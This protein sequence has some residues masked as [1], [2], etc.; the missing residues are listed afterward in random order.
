MTNTL[1][2]AET[3]A[4]LIDPV[5]AE[6]GWGRVDGS[7]VGREVHITNGRLIGGG[8]R[9]R[10]DIADYVLIYRG[11]RLAVIEAKRVGLPDTE[12]VGQAKRY[13]SML[14]AR[15]AFSTNGRGIYRIDMQTGEECYVGRY[16]APEELWSACFVDRNRWRDRFARVPF[17]DR[18][19]TWEARYYQH[20][21]IEQA[22]AAI[23]NGQDR[24]LLTLATGTG[25]TF[26]AFQLA[27]KLFHSRWNLKAWG[28]Q[29][30]TRRPRILFLADRNILADQAYN[31]F[32]A[33]PEDALIRISPEAI[34]KKGRVPKNGAVFFT[35]F[36]TFMSGRDAEG[37][38]CPSFWGYPPDFFDFIVIDECHRGGANDESTWREI[39]EYF[40][41][42][43]QLGL[44][45]TP[46]RTS[47]ADT[48]AYFGE[49]VY[50]YSLRQGINDG[51]L[52]PFKV[53]Q[54]A[55]TI[56]DYMYTSDDTL[57]E[58]EVEAGKR[59]TEED[60]NRIIEIKAR[61][62]YRVRVFM[63]T[64]DQTQKTLV[65]CAT[66]EHALAVRDLI[67]QYKN[68]TDPNYCM[69]VTAN[70]GAEGERWLRVF[71]DNEKSIPTILTTSQKLSTGVDARNIRNIVLMRPINSMVEFKQ[72]IGRGTRLFDGK[73]HFT[74]HDF[75]KAYELFNDA[76]WDGEPMEPEPCPRCGNHP[77]TCLVDPPREYPEGD[78]P[79][80]GL[81]E[82]PD[83][84]PPTGEPPQTFGPRRIRIRLADG[85]E[86]AIQHMMATTFWGPDG[87]PISSTEFIEALYGSLPDLFKDE[88]ELRAIWSRPDTRRKLLQGLEGKGYGVAQLRE[89]GGIIDAGDSDLYDVLAFIAFALPPVSRQ[90]RVSSHRDLIFGRYDHGQQEFLEFVLGHYVDQGVG[91]LDQDKLP[92]LLEL[93]YQSIGDA[94]AVLGSVGGIR[95][96]FVG[97]QKGLYAPV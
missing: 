93:K 70:D 20:N 21:A 78:P 26:I 82:G 9:S 95:D 8:R 18:G 55:T 56:D 62:R 4:E 74:I 32:S 33:F 13:A 65:F 97:F 25:K 43:V 11:H 87:K 5:L 23:A 81:G 27:W 16:P 17:E 61:E 92:D 12:G 48:Y 90:E 64:I 37:K 42:A 7:R 60:F 52:T 54:I 6:V 83:P 34:R 24:I 88:D 91:E 85:K 57:I 75:V 89:L 53:K 15:F 76:E 49:P 31:S 44:T 22:L 80:G 46:R 69:R 35:I 38:P 36:Q 72:I 96:V 84:W 50:V 41:P 51:F 2:E 58:G 40:A 73:D 77:C 47:N 10:Q 59:Y 39:L 94:V 30:S 79:S 68:S 86:R 29:R 67:N 63:D 19:G 71:Q 1:N 14:Q 66:Q 45:A 3:R 28:G